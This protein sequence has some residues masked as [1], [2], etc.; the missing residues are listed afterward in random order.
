VIDVDVN[1]AIVTDESLQE[2]GVCPR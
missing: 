1:G 2:K